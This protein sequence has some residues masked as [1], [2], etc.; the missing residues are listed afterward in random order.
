MRIANWLQRLVSSISTRHGN[1]THSRRPAA[2]WQRFDVSTVTER[3]EDRALLST[4]YVD[5][6]FANPVVGQDPDGAGPALDFGTDSFAT[7][8][9]AVTASSSGDT[10]SVAAGTYNEFVTIDKSLNLL[11]AQA[12]VDARSV[13]VAADASESTID[14]SGLG[15]VVRVFGDGITAKIDG[16]TIQADASISVFNNGFGAAITTVQS[17]NLTGLQIVNNIIQNSS[18]GITPQGDGALI[19]YNL[20]RNINIAGPAA[21][22]GIYTDFGLSNSTI[23]SN[24]SY[25]QMLWTRL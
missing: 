7:I 2:N 21:G 11:G 13:R 19:Q 5:D 6:T 22:T 17:A 20:I 10:V 23:D 18:I 24:Q 1:R 9:G 25:C 12:G 3:L 15:G 14:G 16:F 8:Q 4:F